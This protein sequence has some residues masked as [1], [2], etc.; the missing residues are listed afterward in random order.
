LIIVERIGGGAFGDVYK[1]LWGGTTEVALKSLHPMTNP[2]EF[3]LEV[4]M[5]QVIYYL[6]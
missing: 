4:T 3:E 6:I 2:K 5:L 1:G